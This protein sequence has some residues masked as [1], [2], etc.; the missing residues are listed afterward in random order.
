MATVFQ[1]T[2]VKNL[3]GENCS[4]FSLVQGNGF[5]KTR[6]SDDKQQKITK[7]LRQSDVDKV[8]R[9]GNRIYKMMLN[10]LEV[11]L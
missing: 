6:L 2:P 11:E 8:Y 9:R 1:S 5:S 10:G 7:A 4:T 3:K